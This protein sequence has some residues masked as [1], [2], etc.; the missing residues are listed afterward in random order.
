MKDDQISGLYGAPAAWAGLIRLCAAGLF[1]TGLTLESLADSQMEDHKN[2][3]NEQSKGKIL[4]SGVWS[5][6]RHPN[7]LGD[8]L[9]HFAFPLWNLGSAM[10]SPFQVIGPV[11]NY[12]FL[13]GIGGDK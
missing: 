8:A 10:F 3:A 7:Y 6:V 1:A 5:I 11:A 12:L 2:R 9:C 13:R 4:R